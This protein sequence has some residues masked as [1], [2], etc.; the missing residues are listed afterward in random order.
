VLLLVD[1]VADAGADVGLVAQRVD[2]LAD[3]H[4]R[5]L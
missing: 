5:L 3:P 1:V 4:A 2:L